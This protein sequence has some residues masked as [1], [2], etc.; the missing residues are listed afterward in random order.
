MKRKFVKVMF[1]GALALSTV[2]YVG[3]KDYDDDIDNLQTQIDANKASIADLQKFVDAG[4]W[5]TK[6]DD[7]AGG[8]RI[9]FNNGKTYDVVNGKDGATGPAGPAGPAGPQGKL[10]ESSTVTISDTGEWLINGVSTGWS[11]HAPYIQDGYWYYWSKNENNG[12]GGFVKGDKA[13]GED[14]EDGKGTPGADGFSPYIANGNNGDKGY[15]YFYEPDNSNAIESGE[16]KGWVKGPF[17]ESTITLTKSADKPCWILTQNLDD[18][19]DRTVILPTADNLISLKGV[20]IIDGKIETAGTK[21]IA[22]YYGVVDNEEGVEF[23]GVTYADG[24]VLTSNSAVINA[25]VNPYEIDLTQYTIKLQDSHGNTC[26]TLSQPEKN[27]SSTPLTRAD[28]EWNKGIY[29]LTVSFAEGVN[30]NNIKGGVAYALATENAWGKTILSEYDV[31]VEADGNTAPGLSSSYS[32]DAPFIELNDLDELVKKAG[33][34]NLENVAAY[35]YEFSDLPN[36]V[37]FDKTAKTITSTV[38]QTIP[39][40]LHYLKVDGTTGETELTLNFKS[41]AE[42]VTVPEMNWVVN[43][44]VANAKIELPAVIKNLLDDAS[45]D[46]SLIYAK[47]IDLVTPGTGDIAFAK[48]PVKVD[49]NEVTYMDGSISLALTD[50]GETGAKKIYYLTPTFLNAKVTATSHIVKLAVKNSAGDPSLGT[51]IVKTINLKVNIT[52]DNSKIFVFKP[53]DAF[54]DESKKN[55]SG[56]GAPT[57][58]DVEYDLY[59][60]FATISDAD[61]ANISLVTDWD[62]ADGKVTIPYSDISKGT[63]ATKHDLTLAYQPFANT[64]LAKI[65]YTFTLAVWSEIERGTHGTV[66]GKFLSEAQR[67]EKLELS[68]FVWKD[69]KGSTVKLKDDA[70]IKSITLELSDEAKNYMQLDNTDFKTNNTINITM[71][72]NITQIVTEIPGSKSYVTMKVVDTWGVTTSVKVEIPVKKL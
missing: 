55:A 38:G 42:V 13:T 71:K 31:N 60:L 5:V 52:Q 41:V 17:T 4:N 21:E 34:D 11:A 57:A 65:P 10:G 35:Y 63:T 54:F 43:T 53:L 48:T 16:L 64:N 19:T 70:R 12:K 2:T 20:S 39:G 61:K 14:G 32:I 67:S 46:Y 37:T 56:Y 40:T 44:P 62:A 72:D 49:G 22:L 68:K 25:M 58:T 9:T 59:T 23:D 7:I 27:V 1:F 8:F 3:C 36:T 47:G 51:D 66:T 15:W 28:E 6:V 30:A 29:N 50:N 18:D 24:T 69:V 45:G 33:E 26:F